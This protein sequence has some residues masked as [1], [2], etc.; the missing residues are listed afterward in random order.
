MNTKMTVKQKSA[1]W[2]DV[3]IEQSLEEGF[4]S[5][6]IKVRFTFTTCGI[7]RRKE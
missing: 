7:R 1:L 3:I 2:T 5:A 6:M 4:G